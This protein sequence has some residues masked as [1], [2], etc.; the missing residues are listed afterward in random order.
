VAAR[1]LEIPYLWGGRTSL[2]L[3]CSGLVQTAFEACGIACPRDSDMQEAS[4]G[5]PVDVDL[6][7]L[8]RGDLLFWPG[9]VALARGDGAI[10]HASGH[11]MR[12]LDEDVAGA[13]ARIAAAGHQLRSIRR[14]LPA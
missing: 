14:V 10:V 8:R 3:D 9:H 12:V 2:G 5:E 11:E 13:V 6:A 1:F 4:F 7:Q